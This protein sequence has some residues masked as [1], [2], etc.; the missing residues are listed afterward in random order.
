MQT[1]SNYGFNIVEGTDIVNPLT[2]LNPNFT[3]LDTDLKAVSDLTID[4]ASCIKSGTVHAVTRTLTDNNVFKFTATGNWET[5]D[6]MTVDGVS[7]SVYLPDG[8]APLTGAFIINTEVLC[9]KNGS[10]VTLFASPNKPVYS[11]SDIDMASGDSVQDAVD[12]IGSIVRVFEGQA[13]VSGDTWV[14]PSSAQDVIDSGKYYL[15][16]A[17]F[18]YGD[19]VSG[20]R[21]T[22]VTTRGFGSNI[23][24]AINRS[25]PQTGLIN[26]NA[27][28]FTAYG[29]DAAHAPKLY[30]L[31]IFPIAAY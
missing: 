12:K 10:R 8:T 13:Y 17:D 22:K 15:V 28:G 20:A 16:E 26:L 4:A 25:D 23:T 21:L 31:Y 2:Q 6:T 19:S 29:F 9:I 18:F 5:G 3:A 1:T 30:N 14:L 11:A 27:T 24:A 7:V